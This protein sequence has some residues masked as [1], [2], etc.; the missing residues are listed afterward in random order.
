MYY[1]LLR[2]IVNDI[3]FI[4][5]TCAK[6]DRQVYIVQKNS[7]IALL[8]FG[9]FLVLYTLYKEYIP[10]N[11]HKKYRNYYKARQWLVCDV[12]LKVSKS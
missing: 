8:F 10:K 7:Y 3:K 12:S 4:V 2:F 1:N 6:V 5:D 9:G 11:K